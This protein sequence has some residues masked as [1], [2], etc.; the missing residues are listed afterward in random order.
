MRIPRTLWGSGFQRRVSYP[1]RAK[2]WALST[3]SHWSFMQSYW[4]SCGVKTIANNILHFWEHLI[5][6][7]MYVPIITVEVFSC[8]FLRLRTDTWL[9][10]KMLS[11]KLTVKKKTCT[12]RTIMR[13][14]RSVGRDLVRKTV[15]GMQGWRIPGMLLRRCGCA[16]KL[17]FGHCDAVGSV[18]TATV[19]PVQWPMCHLSGHILKGCCPNCN[20]SLV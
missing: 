2:H 14:L 13:S 8:Y 4:L 19:T 17:G 6:Q 10:I 18:Y 5:L 11:A 12:S 9:K 20:W 3:S 15:A 7:R 1:E 16:A